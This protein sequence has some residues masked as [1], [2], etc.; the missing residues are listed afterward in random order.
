MSREVFSRAELLFGKKRMDNML[1]KRVILFG[2]GGVGSWCAESLVR[3]GI[4][5]ITIVDSDRIAESNINRQ[6]HATSKTVGQVKT[7]VLKE[8]LLDINPKANIT[9]LRKIY[10]EDS[11]QEFELES[12]DFI[13][14]AIDSI[15]NKVHL[16]KT[17]MQLDA[18]FISS[19][20]AALRVDPSR[21]KVDTFWGVR[22]CPLARRIRK[23][24]RKMD[25][26]KKE[27]MCVYSDEILPNIE[28][29]EEGRAVVKRPIRDN[30][31]S[32]NSGLVN[33]DW[34]DC[35]TIINGSLA[36]VTGIFGFTIAGLVLKS[37][38]QE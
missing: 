34:N 26:P 35:K 27:F 5:N 8:R 31:G 28:S 32:D 36:H 29:E 13:I 10:S 30:S 22:G 18:I 2:I 19:M 6:L 9:A 16:I 4:Y 20:G 23:I 3:S 37:I 15:D 11:Y 14:D 12:Y 33:N 38:Y 7:E 25:M 21:I 17:A 1:E 24:L